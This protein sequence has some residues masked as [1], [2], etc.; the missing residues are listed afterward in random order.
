MSPETSLLKATVNFYLTWLSMTVIQVI[1]HTIKTVSYR[2]GVNKAM[3]Q[4]NHSIYLGKARNVI[5]AVL[6][7][8]IPATDAL[9]VQVK[10][11]FVAE[12]ETMIPLLTF[13]PSLSKGKNIF[14]EILTMKLTVSLGFPTPI[15]TWKNSFQTSW[16]PKRFF[17]ENT[18]S[19]METHSKHKFFAKTYNIRNGKL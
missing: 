15:R 19:S 13:L 12:S 14:P 1:L 8:V 16:K 3:D 9:M 6:L 10:R 2:I 7:N 18:R 17:S 11:F 5:N 4:T